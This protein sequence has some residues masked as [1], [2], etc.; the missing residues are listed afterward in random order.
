MTLIPKS[1][2]PISLNEY[3]P[4][5]LIGIL[6]KVV[7]KILPERMKTVMG[8]LISVEQSAFIKGRSILDGILIANETVEFLRKSK[9]KGLIFKVDFEKAYDTVEWSFLLD[10]L[11]DMG[12]GSKWRTWIEACLRST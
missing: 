3:R 1:S 6:Y 12:L 7:S 11:R 5:S 8:R 4:I 9:K 2:C 10:G